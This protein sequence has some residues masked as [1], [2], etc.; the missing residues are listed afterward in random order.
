VGVLFGGVK[1]LKLGGALVS[2]KGAGGG[3]GRGGGCWVG[4][5]GCWGV[6]FFVGGCEGV[7]LRGPG[8]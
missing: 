1:K 2:M 8:L 6:V 5:G 3:G 7:F 4:G